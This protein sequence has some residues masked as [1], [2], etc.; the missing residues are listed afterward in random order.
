MDNQP[1]VPAG[2]SREF[3]HGFMS[4]IDATAQA[5]FAART[6]VMMAQALG[7]AADVST[8]RRDA[9]ALAGYINRNM[10][11]AGNRFYADRLRDGKVS[12]VKTIGAYWTLL[13]GVV[14]PSRLRH[15]V[16]HLDSA[17]EF[18]RPHRVPTL[19]ADHPDYDVK[20]G[21]WRGAVWPPTNYMVLRGLTSTG[22]DGLAAAIA[23]NHHDN[24]VRVFEKTGTVW[25]NYAPE[26]AAPGV[27]ARTNFVGWGGVGP[28]AVFFEYVLGLRPDV[29]AG[30][31]VWDVRL[32]EAHGVKAY[33]F[34]GNG[35]VDLSAARRRN[36]SVEPRI[37]V[38]SNVP[39]TL[40]V[41]WGG[42]KRVVRVK[43]AKA[44]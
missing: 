19:S 33:P 1:R 30:R 35:L 20:G 34:G 18:A 28:V 31:L 26:T 17:R 36:T 29:P 16:A 40:E 25:E 3:H 43:P 41:R 13:A 37:D 8:L 39:F 21:Y 24:V 38:R 2:S 22:F 10:W 9:T 44:T 5:A 11:R 32:A 15:F 4:W 7:R 42:R 14:P 12:S 27:P 6:L 23:R